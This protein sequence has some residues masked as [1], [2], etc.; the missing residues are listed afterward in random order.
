MDAAQK[1]W[2]PP[3]YL[4]MVD[5]VDDVLEQFSK[6]GESCHPIFYCKQSSCAARQLWWIAAIMAPCEL[7]DLLYVD[8]ILET[9]Y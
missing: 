8:I 4:S 6:V 5:A 7:R 9:Y 1:S 2:Y 3:G